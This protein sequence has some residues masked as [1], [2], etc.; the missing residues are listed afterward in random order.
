MT[1]VDLGGKGQLML[2]TDLPAEIIVSIAARLPFS[3]AGPTIEGSR[4]CGADLSSLTV[5]SRRINQVLSINSKLLKNEIANVQY[6]GTHSLRLKPG[7]TTIDDLR[8]YDITTWSVRYFVEELAQ[9]FEDPGSLMEDRKDI[10]KIFAAGLYVLEALHNLRI[11]SRDALP[12]RFLVEAITP[13][14]RA[15]VRFASIGL[16]QTLRHNDPSLRWK[17][18]AW[19]AV[20]I[21]RSSLIPGLGMLTICRST[22]VTSSN[23]ELA[24]EELIVNWGLGAMHDMMSTSTPDIPSVT[25][26]VR[27]TAR[28]FVQEVRNIPPYNVYSRQVIGT[29][30]M[31]KFGFLQEL[32]KVRPPFSMFATSILMTQYMTQLG[33]LLPDHELDCIM[34]VNKWK[35]D[36]KESEVK[37]LMEDIP[38]DTEW[39]KFYDVD[40]VKVVNSTILSD[41]LGYWKGPQT[42]LSLTQAAGEV[43]RSRKTMVDEWYDDL[44][45]KVMVPAGPPITKK[46]VIMS[47]NMMVQECG[48]P[49]KPRVGLG[50]QLWG[51]ISSHGQGTMASMSLTELLDTLTMDNAEAW[52]AQIGYAS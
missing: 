31:P 39:L 36:V 32:C 27:E 26:V 24:I 18:P 22:S 47:L 1:T 4:D 35:A 25:E 34:C 19:Y 40:W 37:S 41:R 3:R 5:S 38:R 30:P 45:S 11:P 52:E 50:Q 12:A 28:R 16:V 8:E 43:L 51:S 17:H 44:K 14:I 6:S 23:A 21:M 2:L 10:L 15:L 9:S 7:D 33:A 49:D 48:D 42:I 13:E 29:I 20:P 46:Y